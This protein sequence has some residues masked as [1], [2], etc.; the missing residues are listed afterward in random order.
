MQLT[1]I[2]N[3]NI[4]SFVYNYL[5]NYIPELFKKSVDKQRLELLNKEF[6]IDSFSILTK[7]L[8]NLLVTKNGNQYIIKINRNIKVGKHYINYYINLINYGNREIKGYPIILDIF[9]FISNNIKNIYRE[10]DD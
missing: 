9:K 7:A 6:K 1:V 5:T 4:D 2:S 3:D 10:W 8:N